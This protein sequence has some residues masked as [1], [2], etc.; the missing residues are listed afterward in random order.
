MA[1]RA[2]S[3]ASTAFRDAASCGV[4]LDERLLAAWRNAAHA[5]VMRSR[6]SGV[7]KKRRLGSPDK[8]SSEL[9]Y[10]KKIFFA[11]KGLFAALETAVAKTHS[12]VG[13]CAL[14]QVAL[15]WARA[16]RVST[17]ERSLAAWRN[18]VHAESNT[19]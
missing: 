11:W 3:P 18:A 7:T 10:G 2:H 14:E 5:G 12:V 1:G 15:A 6:E 19:L 17:D 8:P 13:L 16:A 9:A 4:S